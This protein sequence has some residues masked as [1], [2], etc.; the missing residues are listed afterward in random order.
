VVPKG[1]PREIVDKISTAM[2]EISA[3]PALQ[4]RFEVAGA[5]SVGSTPEDVTALA[6][7]ERPMWQEMVRVSGAKLD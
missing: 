4:E 6:L 2:R 3:D 5:R 7:K 1:T